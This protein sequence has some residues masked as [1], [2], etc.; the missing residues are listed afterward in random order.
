M[1]GVAPV[2]DGIS[3]YGQETD[4]KKLI[5]AAAQYNPATKLGL[6]RDDQPSKKT[7]G[8]VPTTTQAVSK[9]VGSATKPVPPAGGPALPASTAP[10]LGRQRSDGYGPS[11]GLG[12][13]L[14]SAYPF[15]SGTLASHYAHL[16]SLPDAG[17]ELKW[18]GQQV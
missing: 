9:V 2:Q 14:K 8:P 4:T 1:A 12:G 5:A 3:K 18:Y 16:S 13:S 17:P 11:S 15:N 6:T 7:T 10:P